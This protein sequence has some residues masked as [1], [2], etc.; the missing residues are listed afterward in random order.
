MA[1]AFKPIRNYVPYDAEDVVLSEDINIV[2]TDRLNNT[3]WCRLLD[4]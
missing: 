2:D 3:E 1:Y 4:K